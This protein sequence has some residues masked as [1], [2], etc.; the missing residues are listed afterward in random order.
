M[1]SYEEDPYAKK[2]KTR[3]L[4]ALCLFLTVVALAMVTFS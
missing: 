1:S 4:A 2:P 3:L